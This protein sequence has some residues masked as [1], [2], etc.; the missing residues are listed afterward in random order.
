[1]RSGGELRHLAHGA[2]GTC[3]AQHQSQ[4]GA[5][6]IGDMCQEH[7]GRAGQALRVVQHQHRQLAGRAQRREQQAVGGAATVDAGHGHLEHGTDD[8]AQRR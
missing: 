6:R 5:V 3:S 8:Q 7:Q 1:M 4:V 2:F